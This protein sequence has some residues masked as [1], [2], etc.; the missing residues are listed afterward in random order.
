MFAMIEP[1]C[2][3]GRCSNKIQKVEDIFRE[4]DPESDE[5]CTYD[6]VRQT[7]VIVA[8]PQFFFFT[9]QKPFSCSC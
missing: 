9:N 2:E 7:S 1:N 3:S 4:C 6:S 8:R 5:T